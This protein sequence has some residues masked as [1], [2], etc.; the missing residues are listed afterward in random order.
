MKTYGTLG[1]F[2][3]FCQEVDAYYMVTRDRRI[4]MPAQLF[5]FPSL[6]ALP[7]LVLLV[8]ASSFAAHA[9]PRALPQGLPNQHDRFTFCRLAATSAC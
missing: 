1:Q 7:A 4:L 2:E 8:V 3:G 6:S 5:A 9:T